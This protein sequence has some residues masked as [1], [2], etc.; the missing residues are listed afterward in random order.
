MPDHPAMPVDNTIAA[1]QQENAELRRRLEISEEPMRALRAG[2]VDAITVETPEGLRIFALK[3]A[4]QPYRVMV[5]SMS[6]G[7]LTVGSDGMILYGNRRFAEMIKSNL[8]EIFGSSLPT[9]FT[10]A[11]RARIVTA[12]HQNTEI[13]RL[14][15][16]LVSVDGA[17]IPVKVAIRILNDENGRYVVIISD[18]TEMV[19][20]QNKISDTTNLLNNILQSSTRYSIIGIDIDGTIVF[21]NEGARRIYGYMADEIVGQSWD[22]LFIPEDRASGAAN[23]L[24][25]GA[26]SNRVAEGEF[27]RLRKDGTRFPANV[28]VTPREDTSGK[29]IGYLVISS[30]ITEKRQADLRM[31]DAAQYARSLIEASLDPLVTIGT[32]GKI[33]DVNHAA[34]LIT[35]QIRERLIGSDFALYFTEPDKARA[36]YQRV[37]TKGFVID[38]PLAIRH[39]SG[40]VTEVLYNASLYRLANGEVGGVFAAAR[41]ISRMLPDDL[42]P[43]KRRRLRWHHVGIAVGAA[44]FVLAAVVMP[45]IVHD[46]LRHQEQQ[47]DIYR[48]SATNTRMQA[49]LDEVKPTPARVRAAR[50]QP[51]DLGLIYTVIYAVAAPSHQPGIIG[52]DQLLSRLGAE[53]APLSA[54]NCVHLTHRLMDQTLEVSDLII[55]PLTE[56]TRLIGLLAMSWDQ[57]DKVPANFDAA[58]AATMQAGSDI[59]TIWTRKR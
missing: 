15:T 22:I 13:T 32:D 8:D 10:E 30:D 31:R 18:M 38:Y 9:H 33:T 16:N 5:E 6:E 45:S 50:I 46:W 36:G 39:V 3:G 41:D 40:A 14:T 37:F 25:E 34:E 35:G 44:A 21:W 47:A 26:K 1:L 59:A 7:A 19:A 57:G 56:K 23:R 52:N 2:E 12:L 42:L 43:A 58:S 54:G 28:V 24:V 27:D 51:G 11:D 29:P 49:L 48:L 55:C 53:V 20:A 17:R 4:D